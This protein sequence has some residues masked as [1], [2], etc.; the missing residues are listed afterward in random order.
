M[1]EKNRRK[2]PLLIGSAV[3]AQLR[4]EFPYT[5]H[6][7]ALSPSKIRLCMEAYGPRLIRRF[8]QWLK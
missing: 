8:L 5:L 3:F 1:G 6:S 7:A 4:A 2:F